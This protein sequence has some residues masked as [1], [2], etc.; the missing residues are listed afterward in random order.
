VAE[1]LIRLLERKAL[2][3]PAWRRKT[4]EL[5]AACGADVYSVL[6]FILT[7][8]D[9]PPRAAKK[10]W[11]RI[12]ELWER[13]NRSLPGGV[14]LRVAVLH[15]FLRT[16]KKLRNPTIVEIRILRQTQDSAIID[17]LTRLYNFRYFQDR[18]ASEVH[19]SLRYGA[20]L[21]LLMLDIDDFKAYNDTH[22]HLGGNV[23]L[24]RLAGVLTRHL[25]DVDVVA[26]YG[27]EEFALL[28]PNTPK[29]AA[30]GVGE[31]VRG[32]VEAARVGRSRREGSR[33]LSVSVGIACVPGDAASARALVECADQA[34][35][36]AKSKGKNQVRLYS[37]ER[38]DFIRIDT[39]LAGS[40]SLVAEHAQPLTTLNVSEGG[41]LFGTTQRLEVGVTLQVSLKL[42]PE[43]RPVRCLARVVRVI[44]EAGGYEI[45]VRF[46]DMDKSHRRLFNRFVRSQARAARRGRSPR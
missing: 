10:H 30:L 41:V 27:G 38:R 15:Y 33:G 40:F 26:R 9:I 42:P 8:L 31:K 34:L 21:A 25:R 12:L 44:E 39:A 11:G 43:R 28:L 5:E 24:R 32:A 17:E 7:H 22:G 3:P 18:L 1:R 20:P 14:D 36:V 2:R 35:Y 13:L 37:D 45:G 46:I 16:Q 29:A 23:A 6:L 4:E 19:R